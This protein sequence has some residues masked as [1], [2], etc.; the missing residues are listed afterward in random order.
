[1]QQTITSRENWIRFLRGEKPEWMP[2]ISEIQF[3]H[4]DIIPDNVA[5]GFVMETKKIPAEQFGGPDMYGVPWVY[6]ASAGGSMEDPAVPPILKDIEDWEDIIQFPDVD[7]WDWEGAAERNKGYLVEDRLKTTT[8]FTGIFERLIS[9]MGFEGAAMALIDEDYEEELCALLT[10]VTDTNIKLIGKLKQYFDIDMVTFHDDWGGQLSP[11]FSL[12]TC[13]NV[14][15]PHLKRIVDFCHSNGILFELHSC[16]HNDTMVPAMV[17]AGVD[18]WCGQPMCD[19]IA[20]F[21]QYGD[22]IAIGMIFHGSEPEEIAAEFDSILER[23]RSGIPAK[24][25]YLRD[26]VKGKPLDLG[27]MLR[28]KTAELYK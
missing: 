12:N 20:L 17:A 14:I 16:G 5:R 19:K 1:M 2:L 9:F 23:I 26:R 6:E 8:V 22:K 18:A 4:P 21:E 7:S 28:E 24:R 10:K 27:D 3:I 11:F 25:M 13:M 15:V